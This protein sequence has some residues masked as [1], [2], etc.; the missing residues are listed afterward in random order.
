[1]RAIC[2]R[3]AASMTIFSGGDDEYC[4]LNLSTESTDADK[5]LWRRPM[6]KGI[7]HHHSVDFQYLQSMIHDSFMPHPNT[8]VVLGGKMGFAMELILIPMIYEMLEKR[9]R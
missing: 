7:R 1:M 3:L 8:L 9:G 4:F 5:H 2:S 6:P